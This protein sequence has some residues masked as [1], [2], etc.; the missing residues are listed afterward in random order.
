[1]TTS[2]KTKTNQKTKTPAK[3]IKKQGTKTMQI[4]NRH[5]TVTLAPEPQ[6]SPMKRVPIHLF[7]YALTALAF[8]IITSTAAS[9]GTA[10]TYQGRLATG[11]NVAT[12]GLFDLRFQLFDSSSGGTSQSS[13]ITN[14]AVVVSNGLLTTTLDFGAAPFNGQALWLQIDVRTNSGSPVGF[15]ALSPRQSLTPAPYA[16]T[17]SNLTGTLAASQL[18]GSL[19]AGLLSGSYTNPVSFAD[20]SGIFSGNGAGLTN[21]NAITLC[22]FPCNNFWNLFGNAGT[23]PGVNNFLGTT[24]NKELQ[25]KV[26]GQRALDLY[27]NATSPNLIGGNGA[28]AVNSTFGGTIGGGG[29]AANPNL[30]GRPVQDFA[31][32]TFVTLSGGDGNV[33]LYGNYATISG[34]SN[35]RVGERPSGGYVQFSD[36]AVVGGGSGNYVLGGGGTI[37]GG[38]SNSIEA[39]TSTS[40]A[41]YEATIG[42]GLQNQVYYGNYATIAGGQSNL[43][44]N[45]C[46]WTTVG[47]GLQNKSVASY[48]TIGGGV[49]NLVNG[50][51]DLGPDAPY[52]TI[53]GGINNYTLA[54]WSAIGGGMGNRV[55]QVPLVSP[56]YA[57]TVAGGESNWVGASYG[58]VAG[59]AN[60]V[61]SNNYSLVS[62][63]LA[64]VAGGFACA[65]GG[66]QGNAILAD[67]SI[68][69]AANFS[70]IGGGV[71][72]TIQSSPE[73]VISGGA[74]NLIETNSYSAL[75]GGV[76]NYI[77]VQAGLAFIGGGEYN[78]V[79]KFSSQSSVVGGS[80]NRIETNSPWSIIGGGYGNVIDTNSFEAAVGGGQFNRVLKP[81]GTI[82]GGLGALASNYGQQAYASGQFANPGDAQTG[83]YVCR[84]TTSAAATNELF[85][86]G[87]S[88]R[89]MM[90]TN[91]TW[92]FD[93]LVTGR[94]SDGTSAG[95]QL[96][97]TAKNNNGVTVFLTTPTKL[98][99]N[100][101]NVNWDANMYAPATNGLLI[102]RVIGTAGISMRWVASMRT[103]EVTF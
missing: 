57:G 28:N 92:T 90:P 7:V 47:G 96:V 44:G 46:W 8:S 101:D 59:G 72:N 88:E 85:L 9:V 16:L 102:V 68:I 70:S 39:S 11:T 87:L 61:V 40:L 37:G 77:G 38:V 29:S 45:G 53:A 35:N 66:G 41:S 43:A 25:L 73:S 80:Y 97:G 69:Q 74:Q 33:A 103:T 91:S 22:G 95:F 81:Y 64:N 5:K 100:H 23:T 75:G 42:G 36:Y 55:E 65:I 48:S 82:P 89:I 21:L 56:P 52:S 30:I 94:A 50:S 17:S 49:G 34:G 12:T 78:A 99:I 83:L 15:T 71:Y 18:T 86:D 27:P 67:P 51:C 20:A 4:N 60:N 76:G 14:S 6:R 98:L 63:G 13:Q 26:A 24:D 1:V 84:G 79:R 93:I 19:P 2:P 10:F 58:T 32:G 54:A 62:G 31:P 3:L